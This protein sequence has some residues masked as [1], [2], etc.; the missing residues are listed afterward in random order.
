[1]KMKRMLRKILPV[2]LACC[3]SLAGSGTAG[4]E[5]L[6]LSLAESV[7]MALASDQTI[8]SAEADAAA[9]AW[10]MRSARR[11]AGPTVSWGA[12]AYSIGGRDY[13][14]A[15]FDRTFNNSLS[16]EI[17]LY[18]GGQIEGAVERY[19]HQTNAAMFG[20]E[21]ERQA[22]RFRTV[23]AYYNV[24]QRKNLVQVA[25]S[26][27]RMVGEQLRFLNIQF[28]EGTVARSDVIQM[29]VQMAEYEQSLIG[30][31]GD[32]A[33][34]EATLCSVV[35]L[36]AGTEIELADTLTYEPYEPSLEECTDYGLRNRPD[37]AAADARIME[38]EAQRATAMHGSRPRVVGVLTKNMVGS[39]A[40][41]QD[42]NANWRAGLEVRWN[43]FDNQVTAANVSAAEKA[44][45]KAAAD[46][47]ETER[48][49]RLD[50]R[51]AYTQMRTAEEKIH[52]AQTAIEQA[53]KNNVLA[54]VR[55]KE[56]IDVILKVTDAQ[57][58]LVRART[59]YYTA[60]YEYN[61]N[62][63]GLARAM[64]VSV[65]MDVPRYIAAAERGRSP[66]H[67]MEDA[68]LP[69]SHRDP[70]GDRGME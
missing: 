63:A 47:N 36:P 65:A 68:A 37:R 28:N 14:E 56:G 55:Y 53:Q 51:R 70:A 62:R 21:G 31:R 46:A 23:E 11:A 43:I 64:G 58:K 22:V 8:V 69:S 13:R 42:R 67:A 1:M 12:Q 3:G 29:Q 38:A 27:V 48:I 19:R 20:I 54:E 49:I 18:T 35:G 40:F 66:L 15:P 32:L 24:L 16:M 50:I 5:P 25:E 59:N 7:E 52:T 61:L 41:R 26:A 60:L 10:Q 17:P 39:E 6:R 45:E 33:V 4:A 30:A 9:S 44:V 57:E 2:F 34:A